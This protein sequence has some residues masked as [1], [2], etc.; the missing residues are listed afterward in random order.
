MRRQSFIAVTGCTIAAAIWAFTTSKE[1]AKSPALRW[2]EHVDVDGDGRISSDEYDQ[3]SDQK[4]PMGI[5]D[6]TNDGFIEVEELEGFFR[7]ADPIDLV[8]RP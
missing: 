1:Q 2:M 6:V 3:V 5:I 7:G 4:T 8:D